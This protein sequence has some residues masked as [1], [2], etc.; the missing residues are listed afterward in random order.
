[1]LDHSTRSGRHPLIDRGHDL[2]ETRAC[3]VE[4]LLRVEKLTPVIWEPAA[5]HG[6]I[7][8]VLRDRGHA[9]IA[10]DIM[11][12]GFPL[13]FV[14]DFLAQN[15]APAGPECVRRSRS[16]T[17]SSPEA[18]MPTNSARRHRAGMHRHNSRAFQQISQTGSGRAGN[19]R[20]QHKGGQS[21][22]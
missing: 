10:S 18:S 15:K 7:V 4:A 12:R 14:G 1:M 9:V 11:D 8:R 16:S 17:G 20:P 3:A 22:L 19:C 6:A 5:G 13:H 2:Y 21:W